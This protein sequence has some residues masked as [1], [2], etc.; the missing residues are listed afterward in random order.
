[1]NPWRAY[2]SGALVLIGFGLAI[3]YF[4]LDKSN[5]IIW[6]SDRRHPAIDHLLYYLTRLGE[7]PAFV[8][9]GLIYWYQSW[10]KMLAIP[11][12]GVVVPIFSQSLKR[13]FRHERPLL[14]FQQEGWEMPAAVLD[15]HIYTG[16]HSFPSGHSTAAWALFTLVAAIERKYCTS[17]LCLVLAASVSVSRVYLMAHFLRDVLAGAILGFVLGYAVYI[18]YDRWIKSPTVSI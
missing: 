7:W 15:Y 3:D 10:R 16:H 12:I 1:M 9:I 4:S 17:A 6:L 11:L 13:V 8:V 14:Y 18:A 2:V 5:A